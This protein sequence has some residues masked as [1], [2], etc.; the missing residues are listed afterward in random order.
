V[1]LAAYDLVF[2]IASLFLFGFVLQAE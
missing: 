2:T 1:L